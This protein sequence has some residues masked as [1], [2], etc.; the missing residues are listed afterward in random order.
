M[1]TGTVGETRLDSYANTLNKRAEL[2]K[3][4]VSFEPCADLDKDAAA[5]R[6]LRQADG[7]IVV[8]E[9]GETVYRDAAE[10]IELLIATGKP[11]LGTVYL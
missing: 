8:E 10:V 11:I 4:P 7:C 2:A 3:S 6:R 9:V 1:L 5:V